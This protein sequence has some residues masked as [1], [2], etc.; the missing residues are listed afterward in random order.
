MTERLLTTASLAAMLD[1]SPG[2]TVQYADT[3]STGCMS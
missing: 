3:C 1:M 2:M